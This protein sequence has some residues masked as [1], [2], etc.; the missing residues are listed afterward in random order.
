L[1]PLVAVAASFDH[2][3][4]LLPD[5]TV[6]VWGYYDDALM[7]IPLTLTNA[8]S[9]AAGIYHNLALKDD[10]SVVAWGYNSYGQ[11]S[12][13][14]TATNIVAIAGGFRHSL[15]LREDG[16]VLAWGTDDYGQ[17]DVPPGLTDAVAIAA[18]DYFSLA[19]RE[20]GSVAAWGYPASCLSNMPV[21]LTNIVAIAA[22]DYSSLALR[23]DGTV[24]AWGM[25]YSGSVPVGLTNVVGLA[26]GSEHSLA[27]MG[28]GRPVITVQPFRRKVAGGSGARLQVMAAGTAPLSYQWQLDGSNILGETGRTLLLGQ[29]AAAGNYTVIVSNVLGAVTSSASAVTPGLR[30]DN[31]A[32][33][34]VMTKGGLRLRLLGCSGLGSVVVYASTDLTDWQPILTNSAVTGTLDFQDNSATN[35]SWRFYRAVESR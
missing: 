16:T 24:A 10:G 17:L 8:V 22:G 31:S 9:V 13:P 23:S 11:A 20:D 5:G 14:P 18:G 12:V 32:G 21:D 26:G 25:N 4:G 29:V 6:T 34:M 19:L 15:A 27:L 1:F 35:S 33:G 28:D 3:V 30:F 2:D 7:N